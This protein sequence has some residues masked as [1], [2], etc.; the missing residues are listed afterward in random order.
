MSFGVTLTAAPTSNCLGI[1]LASKELVV[2]LLPIL[3]VIMRRHSVD[4]N[5]GSPAYT[6]LIVM[7]AYPKYMYVERSM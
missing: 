3:L 7:N 2:A 4:R 1:L 5:I 6:V